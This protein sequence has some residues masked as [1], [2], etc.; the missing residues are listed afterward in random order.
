[1]L[2]CTALYLAGTGVHYP[3]PP[4]QLYPWV[5]PLSFYSGFSKEIPELKFRLR[6]VANRGQ[7]LITNLQ[8]FES[9]ACATLW[10]LSTW[11]GA[12]ADEE[13]LSQC[14]ISTNTV[15]NTLKTHTKYVHIVC[16]IPTLND[17]ER[18]RNGSVREPYERSKYLKNFTSR[19]CQHDG[20]RAKGRSRS[21]AQFA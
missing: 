20:V 21:Y 2:I 6:S 17:V 8:P 18:F 15:Y 9:D 7:V 1:M 4:Y 12:M 10:L 13:K 14:N 3:E 5:N 19:R 16:G 11:H